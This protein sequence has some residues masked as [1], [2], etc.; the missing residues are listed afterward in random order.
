MGLRVFTERR[1][2]GRRTRVYGVDNKVGDVDECRDPS[3]G[4]PEGSGASS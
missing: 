2:L 1:V 3:V 4:Y